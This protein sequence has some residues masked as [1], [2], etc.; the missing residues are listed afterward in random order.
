MSELVT[1]F[2]SALTTIFV[3]AAI[4]VELSCNAIFVVFAV[5]IDN[6]W[7]YDEFTFLGWDL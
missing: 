1:T 2:G 5:W 3:T 4:V 6:F 7:A